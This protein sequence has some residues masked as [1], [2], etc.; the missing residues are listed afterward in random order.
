M[1][2]SR[3]HYVYISY[4]C[5]LQCSFC[6]EVEREKQVMTPAFFRQVMTQVAPMTDEVCLHLMGEPLGHPHLS[7]IIAIC[8]EVGT[9]VNLTTNGLLLHGERR[10][11]MLAP[12]V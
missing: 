2:H 4:L 1:S 9:P 8:A 12:I 3:R 6:P 11:L 7:E 10:E 5:R